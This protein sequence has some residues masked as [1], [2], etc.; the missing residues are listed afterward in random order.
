MEGLGRAKG[1]LGN[2]E[3]TGWGSWFEPWGPMYPNSIILSPRIPPPRS[4]VS[5]DYFQAKVYMIRGKFQ[6]DM[7]LALLG[8]LNSS[9]FSCSQCSPNP[10]PAAGPPVPLTVQH[11]VGWLE[12]DVKQSRFLVE[13]LGEKL[14]AFV[15]VHPK[16]TS[17]CM[18]P[19]SLT[20]P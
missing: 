16:P 3:C 8:L 7:D 6:R 13:S 4:T 18:A 20:K 15:W 12:I 9:V 17:L 11:D 1:K 5:R 2:L 10:K 14:P 19:E